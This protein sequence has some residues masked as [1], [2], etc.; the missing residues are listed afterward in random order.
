M[1]FQAKLNSPLLPIHPHKSISITPFSPHRFPFIEIKQ[2]I[3][4]PLPLS[5]FVLQQSTNKRKIINDGV[6]SHHQ[7]CPPSGRARLRHHCRRSHR[8]APSPVPP[9]VQLVSRSL[10]L[11]RSHRGTVHVLFFDMAHSLLVVFC[12]LARRHHP[13]SLLVGSLW[14]LG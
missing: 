14:P 10:D 3:C 7:H 8:P 5:S 6:G 4:L 13:Q 11:Y 1:S 2:S 9:C 12:S